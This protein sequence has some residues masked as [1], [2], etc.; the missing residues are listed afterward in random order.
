MPPSSL[1][2]FLNSG[3]FAAKRAQVVQ[4]GAANFT[5]ASHFD[6]LD[7]RRVQL[8]CILKAD[9]IRDFANGERFADSAAAALDHNAFEQLNPFTRTL[10][11]LHMHLQRVAWTKAGDIFAKQI[12]SNLLNEIHK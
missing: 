7:L 3:C 8:Y 1:A 12:L 2:N 11:N 4:L 9:S 10:D 6:L 5:S